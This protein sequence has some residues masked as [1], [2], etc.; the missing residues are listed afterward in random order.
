MNYLSFDFLIIYAF[1]GITL[2]IGI[3]AGRNIKDVKD[4]VLSNKKFY[5]WAILL[6]YLATNIAG[7]AIIGTASQVYS[8][9]IIKTFSLLSYGIMFLWT[10]YTIVPRIANL[11]GCLTLG[12]VVGSFYGEKSKIITGILGFI[13][14]ICR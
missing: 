1:L 2:F 13:V 6:S 8:Q 4:Y 9:G 14:S 5:K 12:D 11:K 7:I 10:A 3:R